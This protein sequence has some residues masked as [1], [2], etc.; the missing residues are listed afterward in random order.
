MLSCSMSTKNAHNR[1]SPQLVSACCA[2]LRIW[3][4][5]DMRSSKFSH[6]QDFY[7]L[8]QI[9][10][11]SSVVYLPVIFC[12]RASPLSPYRR[13]FPDRRFHIVCYAVLT[14]NA[15]YVL[16]SMLVL[17]ISCLSPF[18]ATIEERIALLKC[19]EPYLTTTLL[20]ILITNIVLDAI[21][22]YLPLQLTWGLQT[23]LRKKLKLTLVFTLG[24]FIFIISILRVIAVKKLDRI[25]PNWNAADIQIW[26][27]AESAVMS[28]NDNRI[29]HPLSSRYEYGHAKSPASRHV[30]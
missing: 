6:I 11:V 16:A 4:W 8:N 25:D 21:I 2:L 3:A 15:L 29:P 24:S 9:L 18:P 19:P 1:C 22:V 7:V 26:S 30:P 14:L 5:A 13:L 23:D 17:A 10:I 20:V 12:I 27:I 28:S